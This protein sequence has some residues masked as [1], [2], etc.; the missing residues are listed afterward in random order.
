[1]PGVLQ[2]QVQPRKHNHG[3][4]YRAKVV[5][6]AGAPEYGEWFH[7]ESALRSSMDGVARKLG[8]RYYCETKVITCPECERDE[9]PKVIATL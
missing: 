4:L 2:E 7:S 5:P 1:M 6:F 8:Q 3:H 9:S